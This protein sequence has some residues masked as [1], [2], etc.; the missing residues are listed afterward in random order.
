MRASLTYVRNSLSPV[1]SRTTLCVRKRLSVRSAYRFLDVNPNAPTVAVLNGMP[2]LRCA[3]R[4]RLRDGDILAFITYPRGDD[5]GSQI[6]A[7]VA[8]IVLIVFGQYYLAPYLATALGSVGAANAITSIIIIAGSAL[9]N[10]LVPRPNVTGSQLNAALQPSSVYNLQSQGNQARLGGVIPRIFGRHLTYPDFAAL[11]YAEYIGN[12]QYLYQLFCIGEGEYQIDA[13][14]LDDTSVANFPDAT[15][16]IIKPFGPVTLFPSNVFSS[17]EVAGQ[18]LLQNV[19][20]GPFAANPAGSAINKIAIDLV[21]P[22]ALFYAND[23]GELSAMS[24]GVKIEYRNIDDTGLPVGTWIRPAWFVISLATTTPIRRTIEY[25]LPLGRY[26]VRLTRTDA[27]SV[28]T[29]AGHEIVW[30][31]LRGFVPDSQR[32]P[33]AAFVSP[34]VQNI[35][36]PYGVIL[37]PFLCNQSTISQIRSIAIEVSWPTGMYVQQPSF[38]PDPDYGDY[39]NPHPLQATFGFLF[40]VRQLDINDDPLTG[41]VVLENYTETSH[42]FEG[43]VITREYALVP[44]RYEA[45][46][47]NTAQAYFGPLAGDPDWMLGTMVW[48]SLTGVYTGTTRYG[49]VTLLAMRMRASN[50]LSQQSSR[51]INCV[52]T[53]ILPSWNPTQGWLAPAPQR[54]PAWALLEI[55]RSR[56]GAQLDDERLDLAEFYR[57]SQTW[58]TRGDTFDAVFDSKQSCW[59]ALK[60]VASVGRAAVYMQAGVLRI[61]RDEP[62]TLPTAMFTMRNIVKGSFKVNYSMHDSET[63]DAVEVEYFDES[64]WSSDRVLA[65]LPGDAATRIATTKPFGIVQRAQAWREGMYTAATNKYR[66]RHV[67]FGT[68][69]EGHLPMIGDLITVQHDVVEWGQSGEIVAL[70]PIPTSAWPI[71]TIVTLSEPVTFTTGNHY[72]AFRERAGDPTNAVRVTAGATANE[73]VLVEALP[74]FL[75]YIGLD[76]ERTTFAFGPGDAWSMRCRVVAP[77]S[78]RGTTIE[79]NAVVENMLVHSAD[80]GPMPALVPPYP[81]PKVKTTPQIVGVITAVAGGTLESPTIDVTWPGAPGTAYYLVQTSDDGA[82]WNPRAE[83]EAPSIQLPARAGVINIRVAP[84]GQGRGDWVYFTGTVIAGREMTAP[85]VISDLVLFV[86][87]RTMHLFWTYPNDARIDR[88]EIYSSD[89]NNIFSAERIGAVVNGE[90]GRWTDP[91]GISGAERF[92]WVRI[93]FRNGAQGGFSNMVTGITTAIGSDDI[94]PGGATG[95]WKTRSLAAKNIAIQTF[96]SGSPGVSENAEQLRLNIN[97]LPG[98]VGGEM[99]IRFY[100]SGSSTLHPDGGTNFGIWIAMWDN[101]D[102]YLIVGEPVNVSIV[103]SAGSGQQA[104]RGSGETSFNV[105]RVTEPGGRALRL[106]IVA[107]QIV[108]S[109][110]TSGTAS[111]DD[112]SIIGELIRR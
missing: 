1:T 6:L 95:T 46:L 76:G 103:Q 64:K 19:P 22:R 93:V 41:W 105:P 3:W 37:G 30:V 12:E 68:E 97:L 112:S 66:R 60:I 17:I 94:V 87:Q 92:Y 7:V 9:I 32:V 86:V 38:I 2:V 78:P 85:G 106:A 44:G 111:I 77:I 34:D 79:L 72:I 8:T 33:N 96:I 51:R 50:S 89:I 24:I 10:S 56:S 31:A 80:N 54:N 36:A 28:N 69:L 57:L 59:D 65:T 29:R 108:P 88:V 35:L 99:R 53:A 55:A 58:A 63:P 98:E 101:V 20:V 102:R 45:R 16:E 62:R 100:V 71:G 11:P 109:F 49:N 67:A 23:N 81:L 15:Y 74:G 43:F 40:E 5:G 90:R 107:L 104:F 42:R 14:R 84:V 26:E 48:A 52:A 110:T 4:R 73:V 70:S 82:S 13:I 39:F 21:L 75:W 91:V 18:E 27:K 83:P 47:R 25:A 61:V